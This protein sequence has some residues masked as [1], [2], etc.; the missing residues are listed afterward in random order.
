MTKIVCL[1]RAK[2]CKKMMESEFPYISKH[3]VFN[4]NR[5]SRNSMQLCIRNYA[6]ERFITTYSSIQ[7]IAEIRIQKVQHSREYNGIKLFWLYSHL[8]IVS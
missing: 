7:H 3:Y 8:H 5:A 1:K 2:I 6:H 4:I